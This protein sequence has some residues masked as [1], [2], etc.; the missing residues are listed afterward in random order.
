MFFIPSAMNNFIF[1][2][3]ML[4]VKFTHSSHLRGIETSINVFNLVISS[5]TDGGQ[6]Y[7]NFV[8]IL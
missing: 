2:I 8:I 3:K 1:F 6:I 7:F 4:F 5:E